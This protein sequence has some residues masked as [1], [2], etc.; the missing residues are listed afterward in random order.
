LEIEAAPE[1]SS[2][3]EKIDDPSSPK[4]PWQHG[5]NLCFSDTNHEWKGSHV[6]VNGGKMNGFFQENDGFVDEG[7]PKL[8]GDIVSGDRAMWWYDERDIPFYYELASTFAIGD[9]YHSS[10]IGP[11]WPNRDYLYAAT[12][13]GATT[14]VNPTCKQKDPTCLQ[15]S[16]N[17]RDVVI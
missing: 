13:L 16:F 12:S 6:E 10:L 1:D 9:H 4:H 8:T 3:P 7:K 14:N 5:K 11:T 2:N 17:D 15:T